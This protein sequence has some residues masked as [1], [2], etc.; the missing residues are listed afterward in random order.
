MRAPP[1]RDIGAPFDLLDERFCGWEEKQLTANDR[2][3]PPPESVSLTVQ[4]APAGTWF[5]LS[6]L[7]SPAKSDGGATRSCGLQALHG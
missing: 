5:W 2:D 4:T 6:G 7:P 1:H 3:E